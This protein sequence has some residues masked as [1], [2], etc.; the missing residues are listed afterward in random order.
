MTLP[1]L[2]GLTLITTGAFIGL[3]VLGS[4]R[5]AFT[6]L[7]LRVVLYV[8]AYAQGPSPAARAPA[9]LCIRYVSASSFSVL[10]RAIMSPSSWTG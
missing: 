4:N 8:V 1:K 9:L 2:V 7:D 3:A 5:G 10:S 6:I